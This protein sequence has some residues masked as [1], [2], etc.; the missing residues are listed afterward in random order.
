MKNPEKHDDKKT[1]DDALR[2]ALNMAPI[3]HKE[4]SDKQK[5]KPKKKA[6]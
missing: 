5:K 3:P 2:R 6:P 1:M 4:S